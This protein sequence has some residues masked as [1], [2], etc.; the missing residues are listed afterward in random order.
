MAIRNIVHKHMIHKTHT[1][2][3][4]I[5][6]ILT[7]RKQKTI[8]DKEYERHRVNRFFFMCAVV[9]D[10]KIVKNQKTTNFFVWLFKF[11]LMKWI[12]QFVK[13]V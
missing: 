1:H 10:F 8:L 12:L 6:P 9:G 2:T 3:Q 7:Y 11:M 4:I 5:S 13:S